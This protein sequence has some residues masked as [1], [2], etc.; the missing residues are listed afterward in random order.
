MVSKI[1]QTRKS[2][3]DKQKK[4]L[5]EFTFNA[6]YFHSLSYSTF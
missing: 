3:K 6:E 2:L 1:E 4:L 5:K